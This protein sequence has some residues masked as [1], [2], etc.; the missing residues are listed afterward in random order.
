MLHTEKALAS[1]STS[2]ALLKW[3]P[4]SLRVYVE[5]CITSR[6]NGGVRLKTMVLRKLQ[7]TPIE[8]QCTK[9][10]RDY[11]TSSYDH[12]NEPYSLRSGACRFLSEMWTVSLRSY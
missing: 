9:C 7:P 5:T 8:G 1:L 10:S 12:W 2:P 6:E 11:Q 4:A 3:D